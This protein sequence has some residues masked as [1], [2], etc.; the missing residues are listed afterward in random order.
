MSQQDIGVFDPP[1]QPF[2]PPSLSSRSAP[3]T[4]ARSV[5]DLVIWG[6]RISLLVGFAAT[7]MTMTVGAAVGIAGGYYG[8]RTD[9]VLNAFTNW[10]LVIRGSR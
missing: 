1:G 2:Q 5:L 10:F 8:G 6:A 3:T 7:V 4:S 9:G